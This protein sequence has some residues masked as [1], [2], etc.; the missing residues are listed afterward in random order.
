MKY[1]I[2]RTSFWFKDGDKELLSLSYS[3]FPLAHLLNRL[4]SE[5][6]EGKK[7]KFINI[8]FATEEKYRLHP[9]P[10]KYNIHY[11][12]GH[13]SFADVFDL[14][15][16]NKMEQKKQK[17]FIWKRSHE[18][19]YEASKSI[20][21]VA[22]LEASAHAYAKGLQLDL[23][24]DYKILEKEAILYGKLVKVVVWFNFKE[25]GIYS[26]LTIEKSGIDIFERPIDKSALGNE[27]FLE[28]YKKIEVKEN[29]IIIEGHQEIG[30]LPMKIPINKDMF[31]HIN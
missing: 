20:K 30:Y 12:G 6:Y 4:M 23:N 27:F 8:T 21:N 13:L 26:K 3:F 18:I 1:K 2:G 22:L 28:I 16:F 25:D 17:L 15:N 31:N 19:L 29:L 24:P 10:P 14:E 9:Q 11:Y 5:K 7:L